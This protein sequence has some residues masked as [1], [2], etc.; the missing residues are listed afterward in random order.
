MDN[1]AGNR[2]RGARPELYTQRLDRR[3]GSV[4][5]LGV[6]F[7]PS[8][9]ELYRLQALGL[10]AANR[11]RD[12]VPLLKRFLELAPATADV[13][14]ERDLLKQLESAGGNP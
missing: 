7:D 3:T 10:I 11:P 1:T 14:A 12:A 9:P 5:R 2:R 4:R 6:E 13:Q 8:L